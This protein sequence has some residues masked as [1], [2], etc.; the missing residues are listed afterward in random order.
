LDVEYWHEQIKL[1]SNDDIVI[2]LLGNKKD[3]NNNRVID[4]SRGS[5]KAIKQKMNRFVEVSAKTKENL[6]ET[7]KEFYMEIY[8][9]NKKKIV[10]KRNKNLKAY[11]NLQKQEVDT[12]C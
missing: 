11:Q 10:E 5:Q 7:F 8:H 1:S 3:L 2:Y 6:M 12:C 4:M 9:R